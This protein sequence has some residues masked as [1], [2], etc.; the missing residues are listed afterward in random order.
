MH[1]IFV[2]RMSALLTLWNIFDKEEEEE[3]ASWV[4]QLWESLSKLLWPREWERQWHVRTLSYTLT[5]ILSHLHTLTHRLTHTHFEWK[6]KRDSHFL[7]PIILFHYDGGPIRIMAKWK[8]EQR[9]SKIVLWLCLIG[10]KGTRHHHKP[11]CPGA[12]EERRMVSDNLFD[13]LLILAKL[14]G[15]LYDK[16]FYHVGLYK[17]VLCNS[18]ELG[19]KCI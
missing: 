16:E 18:T 2:E 14:H 11:S 5:L 19:P 12:I 1:Q 6:S 17:H 4:G 8:C 13:D 15:W 3:D 7:L 9:R 10:G